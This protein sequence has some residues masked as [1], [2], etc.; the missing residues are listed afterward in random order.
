MPETTSIGGGRPEADA[1]GAETHPA[2]R[3]LAAIE[4]RA[5]PVCVGLDPVMERLPTPLRRPGP[6]AAAATAL[7]DFSRRVLDAVAP[8]VPCVKIQAA[9][10]ERYRGPG[11]SVLFDLVADAHARGLEVIL[12]AKRGDIGLSARHY[13]AAAFEGGPGASADWI[14]INAYLGADG[15]QPFL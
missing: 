2:D 4:R 8:H 11:M 13:A 6:D 7:G 12:D 1:A 5:A 10:F 15:M 14:T 3:L 9:C